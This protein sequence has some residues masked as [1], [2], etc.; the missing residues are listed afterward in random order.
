MIQCKNELCVFV[1]GFQI[2][3]HQSKITKRG[4]LLPIRKD[5]FDKIF[6]SISENVK[7]ISYQ[8]SSEI[9]EGFPQEEILE[10]MSCVFPQFWKHFGD[11]PSD[12]NL[13][14]NKLNKLITHFSKKIDCNGQLIQGILDS[15]NLKK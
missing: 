2:P 11:N 15:N 7:S 4:K 9:H 6:Q 14:H 1:K 3:M 13:F 12:Q 10:A 8:I 5:D